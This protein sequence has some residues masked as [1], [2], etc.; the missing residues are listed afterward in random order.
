MTD[1]SAKPIP[2]PEDIV[3][4]PPRGQGNPAE[5]VLRVHWDAERGVY[6]T[7]PCLLVTTPAVIRFAQHGKPFAVALVAMEADGTVTPDALRAGLAA[8]NGQAV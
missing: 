7:R 3:I 4:L 8:L 1:A 6:T 5:A 2:E